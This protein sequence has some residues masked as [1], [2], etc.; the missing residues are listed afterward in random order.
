MIKIIGV[1]SCSKCVALKKQLEKENI[2]FEYSTLKEDL[3]NAERAIVLEGGFLQLPIIKKE[4]NYYSNATLDKV[5]KM[6]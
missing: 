3:A 4:D 6:L 5:K 2:E 1:E